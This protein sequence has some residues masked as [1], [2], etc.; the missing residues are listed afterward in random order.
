MQV[1]RLRN[2]LELLATHIKIMGENFERI[3]GKISSVI[4]AGLP[5]S[6]C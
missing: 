4:G 5:W 6:S 2:K 3:T 1:Y